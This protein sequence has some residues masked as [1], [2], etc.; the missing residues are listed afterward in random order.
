MLAIRDGTGYV[1]TSNCLSVVRRAPV[2]GR[3]LR[4]AASCSAWTCQLLATGRQRTLIKTVASP[5]PASVPWT[6]LLTF[7]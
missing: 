3:I 7:F 5:R 4:A 2:D 1:A 6:R